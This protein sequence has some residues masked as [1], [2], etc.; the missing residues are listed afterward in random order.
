MQSAVN[1]IRWFMSGEWDVTSSIEF[2]L[3]LLLVNFAALHRK[4][5]RKLHILVV[6]AW[7]HTED[8]LAIFVSCMN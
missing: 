8:L 5:V 2:C 7:N 6:N 3:P 4:F 1:E